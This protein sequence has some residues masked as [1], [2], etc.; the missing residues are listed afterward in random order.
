MPGEGRLDPGH[1]LTLIMETA[2]RRVESEG[3]LEVGFMSLGEKNPPPRRGVLP[4]NRVH[5]HRSVTAITRTRCDI[6]LD[7][8]AVHFLSTPGAGVTI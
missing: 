8:G 1:P 5:W 7:K 2:G 6:G 4:V 3:W